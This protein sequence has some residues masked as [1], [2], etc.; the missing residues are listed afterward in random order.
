[1]VDHASLTGAALHEP[2]GVASAA[3]KTVYRADGA[4]SGAWTTLG[5]DS[6]ST[7]FCVGMSIAETATY[8]TITNVIPYDDT[9]PQNTEGTEVLTVTHTPKATSHI[10]RVDVVVPISANGSTGDALAA[11]FKNSEASAI[12][13]SAT[14]AQNANFIQEIVFTYYMTAGTTSAITF[15]LRCGPKSGN[16]AYVNGGNGNRLLGGVLKTTIVVTEFKA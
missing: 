2:K 14:N 16:T 13:A 6:V 10:L 3:A 7:G 15:R 4:G 11:L 9:I 12:A 5:Y 1:M 8:S